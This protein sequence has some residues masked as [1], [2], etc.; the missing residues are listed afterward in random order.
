MK[1]IIMK[2]TKGDVDNLIDVLEEWFTE[3]AP[4]ELDDDEVGF[5]EERYNNFMARLKN[6]SENNEGAL[7]DE[8]VI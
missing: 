4:K 3:V 1:G 8:I 2:L 5:N 7:K 6:V